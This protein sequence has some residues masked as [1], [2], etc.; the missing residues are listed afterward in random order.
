LLGGVQAGLI[1]GKKELIEKIKRNPLFRTIR[2]DKIVITALEKI[3][4]SYLS[5]RHVAD[6]KLW[7]LLSVSDG[8]LYKRAKAITLALGNPEFISVEATK[9]Y[10]GGGGLPEAA[11]TSVGLILSKEYDADKMLPL[12]RKCFP[13]IIG[14]IE[15]DRLILDLKAIDTDELKI[16]QNSIRQVLQQLLK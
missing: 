15:N 12:F 4:K 14:R 16:L 1:T 8:E 11:L 13:P 5:G 6:V 10:I 7:Q 9:S 3:L 2:V